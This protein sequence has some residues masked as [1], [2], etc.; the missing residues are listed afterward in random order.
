MYYYFIEGMT[1]AEL[2]AKVRINHER[3]LE[4]VAMMTPQWQEEGAIH[5][6]MRKN[7]KIT[8]NEISELIG[9]CSQVI[10]KFEHG[11]PIRSRNVIAQS[12]RTAINYINLKRQMEGIER[13]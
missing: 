13:E 3:Y 12:Y 10:S 6:E 2:G 11:R 7:N 5:R 4:R 1:N 9:I 8:I